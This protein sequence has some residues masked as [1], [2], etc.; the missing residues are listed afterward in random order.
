M[1]HLSKHSNFLR[2]VVGRI[3][4]PPEIWI[5]RSLMHRTWVFV[6]PNRTLFPACLVR[7][8]HLRS[9]QLMLKVGNCRTLQF[10]FAADFLKCSI[11][12]FRPTGPMPT[13]NLQPNH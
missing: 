6:P 11:I 2:N 7:I 5:R 12:P 9:P 1:V 3:Q 8:V 4:A 10:G 13:L